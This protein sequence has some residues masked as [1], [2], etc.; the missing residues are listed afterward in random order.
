ML[1]MIA[2]PHHHILRLRQARHARCSQTNKHLPNKQ[3]VTKNG[4]RHKI[5]IAAAAVIACTVRGQQLW[6][7]P[8]PPGTTL[9]IST[10]RPLYRRSRP[11]SLCQ[12]LS[13]LD[14]GHPATGKSPP[15]SALNGS[16]GGVVNGAQAANAVPLPYALYEQRALCVHV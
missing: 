15:H 9:D 16:G 2:Q 4:A 14:P 1:P 3:T 12:Q 5:M 7:L 10:P 8:L 6:I 13:C 11:A